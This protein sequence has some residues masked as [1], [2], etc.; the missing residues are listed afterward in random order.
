MKVMGQYVVFRS[1]DAIKHIWPFWDHIIVIIESKFYFVYG[2]VIH[3][4][5]GESDYI[6]CVFVVFVFV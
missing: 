2:R 6:Y 4:S 5:S 1:L 3:H